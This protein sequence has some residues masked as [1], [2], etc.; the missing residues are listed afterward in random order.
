MEPEA[1]P[2]PPQPTNPVH[3]RQS[4]RDELEKQSTPGILLRGDDKDRPPLV[5]FCVGRDAELKKIDESQAKVV[6]ITGI[7]G[8]GKSTLAAQY[9]AE[10]QAKRRYSYLVWRDCKEERERFENQLAA[11]VETLS[12][13]K[14]TGQDLAKQD[15]ESIVRL[16]IGLIDGLD[17][18]FVFDNVDHYVNLDTLRMTSSP[19]LLI[20]AL[21]SANTNSRVL[22]TCRP[23]VNYQHLSALSVHLEGLS[24]EATRTLF[25]ERG[26]SSTDGEIKE[27][28]EVT[29]AHA[30]WLDLL[31]IQVSKLSGVTLGKLVERIRSGSGQLPEKT[32]SSIWATLRER[33]QIVLRSM[34]E[35]VRPETEDEIA[36]Y[37]HL[38]LTYHK[39]IKALNGLVPLGET[40]G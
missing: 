9:F 39:V 32:L 36:D 22:L 37:L 27:A 19:D 26:A 8:Q 17:A 33:E 20:Q 13:G 35:M 11:I 30:F 40:N 21:L 31:S 7:G 6:F 25:S 15:A 14:I 24:F 3:V 29:N 38:H 10:C 12:G 34:A 2:P 28:H 16:L 18:L 4:L 5:E 23:S 1:M